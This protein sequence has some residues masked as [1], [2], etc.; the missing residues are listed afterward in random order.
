ML[1]I[2]STKIKIFDI[3]LYWW[4]YNN[5]DSWIIGGSLNST[6]LWRMIWQYTAK[7]KMHGTLDSVILPSEFY[8]NDRFATVPTYSRLLFTAS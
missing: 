5:I 4:V 7:L 2:G 3:T 1:P 6:T 8:L